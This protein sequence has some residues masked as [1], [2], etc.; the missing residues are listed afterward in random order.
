MNGTSNA[1]ARVFTI[2]SSGPA[3]VL[4]N[5][6]DNDKRLVNVTYSIERHDN[7]TII[8]NASDY[9]SGVSRVYIR[10]WQS[11]KSAGTTIF[12]GLMSLINGLWTTTFNIGDSFPIGQVNFTI[13]A[14]DTLNNTAELDGN[15]TVRL[16]NGYVCS[17]SA[18]CEYQD[19]ASAFIGENNTNQT[20]F[21][22]QGGIW[23]SNVSITINRTLYDINNYTIYINATQPIVLNCNG[24]M[25]AGNGTGM[26]IYVANGN[27]TIANCT[28]GTYGYG[29]YL[30]GYTNR[31]KGS[32]ITN[33]T[34][35]GIFDGGHNSTITSNVF[36]SNS[37]SVDAVAAISINGLNATIQFNNITI[38]KTRGIQ[39]PS[40]ANAHYATIAY[41]TIIMLY[42]S[43]NENAIRSITAVNAWNVTSNNITSYVQ[44][45]GV[46]YLLA[47]NTTIKYNNVLADMSTG[48]LGIW[49]DSSRNLTIESNNVTVR[50]TESYP[51]A[52]TGVEWANISYN[53][54][55]SN[56]SD[57]LPSIYLSPV[58][59]TM[60]RLNFIPYG[61]NLSG[62]MNTTIISNTM[63][64]TGYVSLF[65]ANETVIENNILV[66]SGSVAPLRLI[67]GSYNTARNNTIISTSASAPALYF[68]SI[69]PSVIT[70]NNFTKNI[71]RS[72][73]VND[74]GF[75]LDSANN[76]TNNK[77]WL[78]HLRGSNGTSNG[79]SIA[80]DYC[81]EDY[82]NG[83]YQK[84]GN[85]YEMNVRPAS[86]G[87]GDCGPLTQLTP[88]GRENI[89]GSTTINWT[90]QSSS[91]PLTYTIYYSADN[92]TSWSILANNYGYNN[93]F[94]NSALN[95][96]LDLAD[97]ALRNVSYVSVPKIANITRFSFDIQTTGVATYDIDIGNDTIYEY[98]LTTAGNYSIS[99]I[100]RAHD[101]LSL[102]CTRQPSDMCDFPIKVRRTGAGGGP[103]TANISNLR[104][105][106]TNYWWNTSLAADG[107]QYLNL[108]NITS[109]D[110]II[111]GTSNAT[112]RVF[113][114]DSS[115][116]AVVI[117][118][119][120]DNDKRLVNA[121]Y[122]IERHDNLT[123]IVNASDYGSGVSRVYI[124]VWQSI[125]SAGTTI[126]TGLMSLING[127][128]TTT[129]NIG[130]SFPIGQVNFTIYANDTL[131][132][133]AELDGNF[134]VR[135][136]N[137]YI[138]SDSAVCE[139]QDLA[140]AFIGENNTNQT[141]FMVQGGVWDS[142]VSITINR[143]LYDI[144][145]YTIYINATLPT[146]INCNHTII[147]GNGTG[148]GIYVANGNATIANCTIGT[149]GYGM[150]LNGYTNRVNGNN[151][152]NFT[153]Y[154][155]FDG[156]HNSTIISNVFVSNSSSVDA[157]AAIAITG[158][159]A[160]MAFNNITIDKAMGIQSPTANVHYAMIAYNNIIMLYGASG[161]NAI[162]SIFIANAWN[163]TSNNITSYV[164]TAG[165]ISLLAHNTTIKYNNVLADMSTTQ[166]G[167]QLTSSRNVTIV[168]NNVTVRKES[169]YPLY[170]NG[171]EWANISYNNLT[172][173]AS[174]ALNSIYLN[175]ANYTKIHS[176]FI[177]Y[178]IN[179]LGTINTT[180]TSNIMNSTGYVSLFPANETV[181]E[182]NI[183]V[184]SG[185]VAPLRLIQGSYN[186]VRNNTIISTASTSA[187]YFASISPSVITFN[188]FTKNILRSS[189]V[190][191]VGFQ[192]DSAN[193]ITSNK[194]WLN[195]FRGGNGTSNGSS[196]AIDY[197]VEDY[198]NGIYHEHGNFYEMNVRPA[199]RGTGDCGPLTQTAPVGGDNMT[200]ATTINWTRQSSSMPLSYTIYYSA[201]N[202]TS[203]SIL[204]NNYGYNNT[205]NN[206]A[207]NMSLDLADA[208]LRNVSYV[209]VPKIA[210]ITRFS[211]D[212][213]T[214]GVATYD[215]DIG[216]DTIYEYQLTTA[217]NYSISNISRAHDFLS[218]NCTRQP[219]DMCDFPIKVRRTGAGGGP[220]TANISNLRV[221]WTNYWWNISLVADGTDYLINITPNDGVMNGTSNAT[222]RVFTIDSS[223]P[224]IVLMNMTDND[225]RLVNV[226]YSIERHDNL[227]IIVNAS[228]YG[229]GVSRVYIRVWQSIK[230]AGTTIFTGLMSLING[231]WTTT[232][233]IGDSFPIGQ[234]NFTIYAND[235]LNNTAELD[236]NFTVRLDNGY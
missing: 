199:S 106:W 228:D 166:Y 82:I 194:F 203:W 178:G 44:S 192:L 214:T 213:Q 19:L 196:I 198:I 131:N 136:D 162:N 236:G 153:N 111:N 49:L 132:N 211:F 130:D 103:Y 42:G 143:T 120:T 21:M 97:A 152:T 171:V 116:P 102:N 230:S 92:G 161:Q 182:N 219:S 110:G 34:G 77:F 147:K 70:F 33:F 224:A 175:S 23:D 2:D 25:M 197:C 9:G 119:M 201:D 183:L 209:S 27:A 195:H 215:I 63:N 46:I 52:L 80:I 165:A 65:S 20:I 202:G 88:V 56:A 8:V 208:A 200:G 60:I 174:D 83:I 1:T 100:S 184:S 139:Y 167:I 31:V 96:S 73:G 47:H 41:N 158:L 231:L 48:Q 217:G 218:L 232:F 17:D 176:N 122:S 85:F 61:I 216:N 78:N 22:V 177:P 126:F 135:L 141:I 134:T 39:S 76:I 29:M 91:M 16:D 225:K 138:C 222:A 87:T 75:Q 28:L 205:F 58:N 7:L 185:N 104:V 71:L 117:M 43:S 90:R 112:A 93:T 123:I 40:S 101:F 68:A 187:I 169:S 13:Y 164:Q 84:H 160:T 30:N 227:T 155:I 210:N 6:T 11:I 204:A 55:T 188:N 121:T 193:N 86:R 170:L 163:V 221:E 38:G 62:A 15:F 233:N 157:L 72:S 191:D 148:M 234:V 124:R 220:Y 53:N 36:V 59:N 54:L 118:N 154:G 10:V 207:L 45:A 94:N 35:Y 125:K 4:M 145:N 226:T 181:I 50:M 229:S 128:W 99:N 146:V 173:N 37:S 133:T 159:N 51:L 114:I 64:S 156:S 151:I 180:I 168:S 95:M 235:T 66:S 14:N 142:N 109:N 12:T 89:T 107:T 129:F 3:I 105:E 127:L 137:G 57:G 186:T 24:T 79:S 5:M 144:N 223:G 18:V 206:S 189:G 69:S 108:I 98:Q 32:N 149:F 67:Q 172:S 212:I 115:N 81:V 113:T 190:N 179:L 150:Y 140:S 74:V 26:G